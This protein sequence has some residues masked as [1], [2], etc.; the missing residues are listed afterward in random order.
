MQVS[1]VNIALGL[2]ESDSRAV[3][4]ISH[5]VLGDG[6]NVFSVWADETG[7]P[8]LGV[9]LGSKHVYNVLAVGA[10]PAAR[11]ELRWLGG[12]GLGGHFPLSRPRQFES[13]DEDRF[14]QFFID[15]DLTGYVVSA[16][17]DPLG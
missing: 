7:I 2:R 5:D 6:C 13:S 8:Q 4:A 10:A 16:G 14:D 12:Y 11:P 15:A 3:H 17:A 9:K 1:P